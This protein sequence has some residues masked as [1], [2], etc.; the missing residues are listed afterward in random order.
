MELTHKEVRIIF[1]KPNMAYPFQ[2][3][4]VE[5]C[6]LTETDQNGVLVII[7]Y[8]KENPAYRLRDWEKRE[9]PPEFLDEC[10]TEESFI[11]W[12]SIMRIVFI[13]EDV[14]TS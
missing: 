10:H 8:F 11:P 6:F 1:K 2:G 3:T 4:K 5:S 9:D 13:E 14:E 12:G 7:H